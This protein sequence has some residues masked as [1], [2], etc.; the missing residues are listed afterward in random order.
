MRANRYFVSAFF[1]LTLFVLSA[2]NLDIIIQNDVATV[3]PPQFPTDTPPPT[4]SAPSTAAPIPPSATTLPPTVAVACN[5]RTD[6]PQYRVVA[7]DTVSNLAER[8]GT[9]LSVLVE[10]NCLRNASLITVGQTLRLPRLP[11]APAAPTATPVIISTQPAPSQLGWVNVSPFINADAGNFQLMAGATITI[12]WGD[13]SADVTRADFFQQGESGGPVP[14]GSDTNPADGLSITWVAPRGFRGI[15]TAAASRSTGTILTPLF[16]PTVYVIDPAA[17]SAITLNTYM[18]VEGDTYYIQPNVPVVLNWLGA[19]LDAAQVIFSFLPANQ[20][21]PQYVIGTD[22]SM[23]DG[24]S[25]TI[26][27]ASGAAGTVSAEALRSDGSRIS[28]ATAIRL[29]A[30]PASGG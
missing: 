15:I 27:L 8:T 30:A 22:G 16:V 12:T 23:A 10:A 14:I 3:P 25:A 2:C 17:N 21:D 24:A 7:G 9:T 29:V 1:L 20:V 5:P 13:V 19:P 28:L 18:R 6:W 11:S 4:V 26:T